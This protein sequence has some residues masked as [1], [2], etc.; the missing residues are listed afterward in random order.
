[1]RFSL[2]LRAEALPLHNES[3]LKQVYQSFLRKA[4]TFAIIGYLVVAG[5]YAIVQRILEEDKLYTTRIVKYSDLGPPPPLT[6]APPMP[7]VPVSA[8]SRP[9]VGVPEPVPDTEVSAEQ[10]I[11]TQ[12]EMSQGIAP[13]IREGASQNLIIEAPREEKI[14]VEEEALPPPEE[15][16]PYEEPPVPIVRIQPKYPEMA[17]KAGVE[18]VVVLHVLI[19]KAGKV[20]D[21]RVIKGIGAGLDEAAVEATRQSTWTPAIQ[22]HKPVA[23]W[24]SCPVRFKLR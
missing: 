3:E 10:T 5:T 14:V 8:P 21:I 15:F 16:V 17:R 4:F 22:N 11:A 20:R 12:T 24:V 23:V 7:E 6:D 2:S 13:I 18:G 1:M 9:V 19:D